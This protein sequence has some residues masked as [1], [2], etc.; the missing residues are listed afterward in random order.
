MFLGGAPISP[1]SA[2]CFWLGGSFLQVIYWGFPQQ[3]SRSRNKL[4]TKR[5]LA[6]QLE[7]DFFAAVPQTS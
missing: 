1:T 6:A 7:D 4:E 3:A 5:A 2:V